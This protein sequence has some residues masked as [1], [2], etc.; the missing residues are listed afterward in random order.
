MTRITAR[1]FRIV[2][3]VRENRQA[4][5]TGGRDGS[6]IISARYHPPPNPS[7]LLRE[8]FA[9]RRIVARAVAAALLVVAV[10]WWPR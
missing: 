3:T 8:I 9:V 2:L 10:G 5:R 1:L 6:E 4:G 7:P